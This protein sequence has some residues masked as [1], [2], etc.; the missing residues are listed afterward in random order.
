MFLGALGD[1]HQF[2]LIIRW[3]NTFPGPIT[4]IIYHKITWCHRILPPLLERRPR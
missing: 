1:D 2:S 4:P 3:V